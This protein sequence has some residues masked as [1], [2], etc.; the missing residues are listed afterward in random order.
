MLTTFYLFINFK[1]KKVCSVFLNK[2]YCYKNIGIKS[3]VF[4]LVPMPGAIPLSKGRKI[5]IGTV[6]VLKEFKYIKS[7][8]VP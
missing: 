5:I 3:R 8:M 2:K 1:K 7:R 6:P 4:Y